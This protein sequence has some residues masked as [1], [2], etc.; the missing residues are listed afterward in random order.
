VEC[1]RLVGGNVEI[2]FGFYGYLVKVRC[3]GVCWGV[4]LYVVFI[5]GKR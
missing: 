3:F 2:M 5:E 4:Y 1:G